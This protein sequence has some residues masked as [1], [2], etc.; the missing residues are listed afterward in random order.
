MQNWTGEGPCTVIAD[1]ESSDEQV[2]SSEYFDGEEETE[3]S[4]ED[5]SDLDLDIG[6]TNSKQSSS[7]SSDLLAVVSSDLMISSNSSSDEWLL[8]ISFCPC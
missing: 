2:M 3:T 1:L 5:A 8:S 6:R 7:E 4:R